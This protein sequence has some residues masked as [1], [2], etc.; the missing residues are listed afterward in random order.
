MMVRVAAVVLLGVLAV[1]PCWGQTPGARF[2]NPPGLVRPTGYTHVVVSADGR[3]AYVAGQVAFDSTGAVVGQDD[4]RAQAERVYANLRL[5][6]ASV[7]ASFDDLLKTTT[8]VTDRKNVALLREVRTRVMRDVGH[9]P[10]NTLL[11]VNGL[12]RPELLLEIEAV[13]QVPPAA[14]R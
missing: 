10:A 8:Y 12:A 11:V 9:P 2:I 13:A 3:T 4:F 5:A 7:G 6:L 14:G 1:A